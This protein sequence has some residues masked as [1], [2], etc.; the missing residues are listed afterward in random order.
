LPIRRGTGVGFST[1]TL[2]HH[3]G[4][5]KDPESFIPE[6]FASDGGGGGGGVDAPPA[7]PALMASHPYAF[8]PFGGGPPRCIG[9]QLALLES[10]VVLAT[11]FCPAFAEGVRF[12]PPP[13]GIQASDRVFLTM[14][15]HPGL[16]VYTQLN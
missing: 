12:S 16:F 4:L 5:W 13:G 1:Y 11:L 15:A 14:R 7:C 6:R 2:H 9:E 8:I 10:L 3:P